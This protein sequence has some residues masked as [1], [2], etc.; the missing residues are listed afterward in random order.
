MGVG[1]GSHRPDK[2]LTALRV[3]HRC[4]VTE[5]VPWPHRA[6][7]SECSPGS[8]TPRPLPGSQCSECSPGAPLLECTL[9]TQPCPRAT[10]SIEQ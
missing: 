2:G 3:P 7:P 5:A 8:P 1:W 6:A 4:P 10:L 9:P